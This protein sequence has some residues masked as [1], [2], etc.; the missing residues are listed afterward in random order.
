MELIIAV[1]FMTL[2]NQKQFIFWKIQS[3]KIVG[4]YKMDI[5]KINIENRVY[6]YYFDKLI[7]AKKLETQHAIN[8]REKQ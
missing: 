2:A 8:R 6:N 5:K 3:L 7:V 4:I 1:L